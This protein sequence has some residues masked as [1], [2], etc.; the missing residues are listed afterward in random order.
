MIVLL[1]CHSRTGGVETPLLTAEQAVS[2]GAL[3]R[4]PQLQ[5]R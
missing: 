1:T 2:Q 5:T 3:Q 4:I